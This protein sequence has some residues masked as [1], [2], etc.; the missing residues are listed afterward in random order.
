ML[1]R[2]SY[3]KSQ[4]QRA[5]RLSSQARQA[6]KVRIHAAQ[7]NAKCHMRPVVEASFAHAKGNGPFP[8]LPY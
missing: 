8:Y 4:E 5:K 7:S 6:T 3:I 2:T 1:F